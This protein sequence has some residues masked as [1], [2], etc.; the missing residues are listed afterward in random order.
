MRSLI[1]AE[2]DVDKLLAVL[3]QFK[4]SGYK[5]W[6]WLGVEAS[7]QFASTEYCEKIGAA[8]AEQ[9]DGQLMD[10]RQLIPFI[11]KQVNSLKAE[12]NPQKVFDVLQK[13]KAL[14]LMVPKESI[15]NDV[16]PLIMD[17]DKVSYWQLRFW[18]T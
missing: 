13:I 18:L 5:D 15:S 1:K 10:R 7:V 17:L 6:L 2:T 4:E 9:I 14:G 16:I 11:R 8:L 12:E 3:E